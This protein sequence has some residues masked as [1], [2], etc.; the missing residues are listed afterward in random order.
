LTWRSTHTCTINHKGSA[1]AMEAIGAVNIFN[2]SIANNNL[3]YST[4][5]GDGD[6][7][8]HQDIVKA[9]PYPGVLVKRVSVLD[10][11]RKGLGRDCEH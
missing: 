10:M 1:G 2:R 3:R 9:D 8:S 6:S 7:K 5:R 4:Y 11:C